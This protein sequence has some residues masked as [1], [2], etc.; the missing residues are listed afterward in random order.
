MENKVTYYSMVEKGHLVPSCRQAIS[1]A[2]RSMDGK[3]VEITIKE[4]KKVRSLS[5]N[6]YYWA[7]VLPPIVS[8]FKSWGN[9]VDAL[10]VHEYLK[11]EV[12]K[13]SQVL[14]MPDGEAKVTVSSADLKTVAFEEYLQKVRMWAAEWDLNIPLPNET[15]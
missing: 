14:I 10:Q 6:A 3:V 1:E 13:L 9:N 12:G 7:V 4:Q 8:L 2:L 11:R 15:R 5:Q